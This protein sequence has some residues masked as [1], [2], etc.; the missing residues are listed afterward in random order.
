MRRFA[1]LLSA[2]FLL[3]ACVRP[4]ELSSA[5]GPSHSLGDKSTERA[6]VLCTDALLTHIEKA[7]YFAVE[8]GEPLCGA[9][10]RSVEGSYRAAQRTTRQPYAG[11]FGRVVRFDLQSSTIAVEQRA[12]GNVRVT[13][14]LSVVVERFGRDMKR[15]GTQAAT[16][17]ASVESADAKET[18]IRE[19]VEAAV[20][21]VADDAS[22]LLYASLDGPRQRGA[23]PEEPAPAAPEPR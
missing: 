10:F 12:G 15:L 21:Q 22:R 16:G 7:S 19:A 17:H 2:A 4:I 23:A 18:V 6:G 13:C 5:L 11:E 9:L 1:L 3:G 8:L 20:G 14:A